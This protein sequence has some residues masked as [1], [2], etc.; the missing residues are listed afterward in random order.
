MNRRIIHTAKI[1][2]IKR[3]YDA[4]IHTEMRKRMIYRAGIEIYKQWPLFSF[5][6]H[7]YIYCT[8]NRRRFTPTITYIVISTIWNSLRIVCR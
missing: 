1:I 2:R 3:F 5:R 7:L 8:L 4:H 6:I